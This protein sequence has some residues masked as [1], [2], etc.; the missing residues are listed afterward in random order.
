M[1]AFAVFNS[2]HQCQLLIMTHLLICRAFNRWKLTCRVRFDKMG[3][4][5][6]FN[7]P[8]RRAKDLRS[9][10]AFR[11]IL[12]GPLVGESD[13]LPEFKTLCLVGEDHFSG[14]QV[15]TCFGPCAQELRRGNISL[16]PFTLWELREPHSRSHCAG[17]R[18]IAVDRG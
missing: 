3:A 12:F 15:W 2:L 8:N 5:L 10:G 14:I 9:F 1:G 11:Q 17:I 7:P 13:S 16:K 6:F 18:I 4:T